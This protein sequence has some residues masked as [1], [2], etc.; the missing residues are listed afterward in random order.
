MKTGKNPKKTKYNK[1]LADS[2][3]RDII[4]GRD[5]SICQNCK[6]SYNPQ[7]AHIISRRYHTTR[8]D[9][10]N[11][12][13]LCSKCHARWT[14]HPLEWEQWI[15]KRIGQSEYEALKR[16]ALSYEKINYKELITQLQTI[17]GA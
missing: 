17:L 2:L 15:I 3:F 11:A 12:L 14:Y 4:R 8:W 10:N 1:I 7:V 9:I 16:E 6:S 5:K 13:I